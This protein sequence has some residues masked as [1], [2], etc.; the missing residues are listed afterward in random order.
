M[1]FMTL[2]CRVNEDLGEEDFDCQK[3]GVLSVRNQMMKSNN[4]IIESFARRSNEN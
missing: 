3:F 4:I 1:D 2:K